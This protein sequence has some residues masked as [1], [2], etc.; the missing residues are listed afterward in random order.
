M[1]IFDFFVELILSLLRILGIL[2]VYAFKGTVY[3]SKVLC[4]IF[5]PK[6]VLF[7]VK[8][9]QITFAKTTSD[10][11]PVI[12]AAPSPTDNRSTIMSSTY[13]SNSQESSVQIVPLENVGNMTIRMLFSKNLAERSVVINNSALVDIFET[14]KVKMADLPLDSRFA[15][16]DQCVHAYKQSI[17]DIQEVINAK[18]AGQATVHL[19]KTDT[20][21]ELAQPVQESIPV[22]QP[23]KNVTP[24][25][26]PEHEQ[27]EF[28]EKRE[29]RDPQPARA[30]F[31][32]YS[33]Y[34]EY[35]GRFL[36]CGRAK[37]TGET[38]KQFFIEFQ[39]DAL[40]GAANQVWGNDLRNAIDIVKPK[41]GEL[42]RIRNYGYEDV[43]LPSGKL[44]ARQKFRILRQ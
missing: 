15:R 39:D 14:N 37:K 28:H 27:E 41:T 38:F 42:I 20:I 10:N 44:V 4:L 32:K 40:G 24:L 3:L 1:Y 23:P 5:L 9:R 21:L 8:A 18:L 17:L 43:T 31:H 33:Q 22:A 16:A 26:Q 11:E 19:E 25:K 34:R 29:E 2:V 35:T 12:S 7:L 13:A 30:A 36:S 6:L